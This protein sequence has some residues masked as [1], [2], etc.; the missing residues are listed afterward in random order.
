MSIMPNAGS[1]LVVSLAA[2]SAPSRELENSYRRASRHVESL[3]G[4]AEP[5]DVTDPLKRAQLDVIRHGYCT[6]DG[7]SFHPL[8]Y[9]AMKLDN[10]PARTAGLRFVWARIPSQ[11]TSPPLS[12]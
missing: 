1:A 2:H 4:S 12:P 5:H 3:T 10:T 6:A 8:V 9:G 11:S 7:A